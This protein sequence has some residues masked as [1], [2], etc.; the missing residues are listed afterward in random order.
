MAAQL[1]FDRV[2]EKGIRLMEQGAGSQDAQGE[3]VFI[4]FYLG[5]IHRA[6]SCIPSARRS[7]DFLLPGRG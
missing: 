1:P 3:P 2:S 4:F 6:Q 5:R 7:A